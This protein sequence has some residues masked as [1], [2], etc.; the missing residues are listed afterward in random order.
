MFLN[1][2]DVCPEPVL[3]NVHRFS[4]KYLKKCSFRTISCVAMR[5]FSTEQFYAKRH[6]FLSFPMFVPSL[7]W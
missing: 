7:S 2:S 4:I 5:C 1:I 6:L 3:A